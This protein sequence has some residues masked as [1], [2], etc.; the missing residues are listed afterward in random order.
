MVSGSVLREAWSKG[1]SGK[2]S[3]LR[4]TYEMRRPTGRAL[5]YVGLECAPVRRKPWVSD[6]SGFWPALGLIFLA[7]TV[8]PGW[9]FS[10]GHWVV[11]VIILGVLVAL[12]PILALAERTGVIP[13]QDAARRDAVE[14]DRMRHDESF[15]R[16]LLRQFLRNI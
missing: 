11:A 10:H 6:S 8:I 15:G 12:F 7:G 9:L 1:H 3:G 14:D 2:P 4:T 13:N 5:Y 16:Y